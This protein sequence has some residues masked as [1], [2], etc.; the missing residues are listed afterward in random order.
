MATKSTKTSR[1]LF[2]TGHLAGTDFFKPPTVIS[3]YFRKKQFAYRWLSYPS[4][5]RNG[6][7]DERGWRPFVVPTELRIE[8]K[9]GEYGE[10]V[11][12]NDEGLVIRQ[13]L[14][15][16]IRP[17]W[18]HD[19]VRKKAFEEAATY[20]NSA[21]QSAKEKGLDVSEDSLR[22]ISKDDVLKES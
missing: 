11:I 9:A 2:E 13:D 1:E 15:L 17:Q 14:V 16:C 10:D 20:A 18:M 5:K 21:K 3:D 7:F 4:M 22:R 12:C 8:R 6:G 19:Q